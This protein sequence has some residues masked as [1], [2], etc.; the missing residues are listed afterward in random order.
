MSIT[1]EDLKNLCKDAFE[2]RKEIDDL[3]DVLSEKNSEFDEIEVR[4]LDVLEALNLKSFKSE[5]GDVGTR[6]K[7]SVKIPQGEEK[8]KFFEYLKENGI[9][10]SMVSVNSMTLNAWFKQERERA[11]AEQRMLVVPGLEA[12][13]STKSIVLKRSK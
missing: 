11:I 6:L 7:E 9:F 12:T 4:I 10:D 13:I 5:Y 8:V 3:K 2:K 1:V